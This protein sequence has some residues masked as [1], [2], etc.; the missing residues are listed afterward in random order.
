MRRFDWKVK[1]FENREIL[2]LLCGCDVLESAN[3]QSGHALEAPVERYQAECIAAATFFGMP[4]EC[5]GRGRGLGQALVPHVPYE[6]AHLIEHLDAVV[7]A[8]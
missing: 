3:A 7:P 4:P 6:L 8:V 2:C 5:H 1:V